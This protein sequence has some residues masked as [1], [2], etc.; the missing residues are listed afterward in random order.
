MKKKLTGLEKYFYII[1]SLV[2][3]G[4]FISVSNY[5]LN[6]LIAALVLAF[7]L[8]PIVIKLENYNIPRF[9]S[10]GITVFAFILV[11]IIL[12]I[13]FTIGITTID[14][15]QE[16]WQFTGVTGSITKIQDFISDLTG[17]ST[18]QISNM[19]KDYFANFLNTSVTL[20][21]STVTFT[22]YFITAFIIFIFSLF[23]LLYY[24]DR[25]LEFL[26]QL[27]DEKYHTQVDM[28]L[29]KGLIVVNHYVFGLSLVIL[30][31]AIFNSLGLLIIGIPHAIFFGVAAA[32]LNIIPY[33]GVIIGASIPIIIALLTK[34]SLWYA[35]FVLIWFMLVQFV[36]GN[37]LTPNIVGKK[38]RINP[39][40][41]ILALI[42]GGLLF[43]IMGIIFAL[44]IMAI[45]KIVC[46]EVDSLKPFGYIIGTH[47]MQNQNNID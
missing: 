20:L 39:F 38:V 13:F 7:A 18:V 3:T 10:T 32:I 6:P 14:L 15:S 26:Y 16:H 37:L 30:I 44:P 43:G 29:M 36:E 19:F 1:A 8:D 45:I 17:V 24:R 46:D 23:F 21:Q 22:T 40:A 12:L 25:F 42:T 27:F 2:L 28:T 4:Y 35:F 11:I 41:A 47:N 9:I 5:I 34:D 31:L 33:I